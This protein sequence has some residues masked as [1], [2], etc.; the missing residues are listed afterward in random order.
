MSKARPDRDG[1][2]PA[3]RRS[4]L[5]VLAAL[6]SRR[7]APHLTASTQIALVLLL[8]AAGQAALYGLHVGGSYGGLIPGRAVS[9]VPADR[10]AMGPGAN[11]TAR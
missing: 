8:A 11:N 2:A 9:G 7:L 10:S 1:T 4:G 3:S 5:S 6:P